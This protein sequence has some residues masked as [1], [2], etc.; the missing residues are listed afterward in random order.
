M[1]YA[2]RVIKKLQLLYFFHSKDTV[3]RLHDLWTSFNDV[4]VIRSKITHDLCTTIYY[5]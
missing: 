2:A 3:S 1:M 5:G 4:W